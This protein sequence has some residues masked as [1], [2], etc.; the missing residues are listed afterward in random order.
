MN[1]VFVSLALATASANLYVTSVTPTSGTALTLTGS[2]P[3]VPRRVLLTYGSEGSARTLVVTGTDRYGNVISETLAVPS[4]G[5]GTVYTNQDFATVTSALPLGGGWTAAATLGTNGVGSG[6]WIA[7]EWGGVGKIGVLTRVV[8]GAATYSV[9][10]TWDDINAALE[11]NLLP[12]GASV[13]PLSNVPPVAIPFEL[14]TN[15]ATGANGIIDIPVFAFRLTNTSGTGTV[16]M[17]AIET[18]VGMKDI[19]L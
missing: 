13:E 18:T 12:Y 9:E 19:A 10:V 17:Q 1:P 3:A 11:A 2:A 8:T 7:R 6:P 4:G 14:F 5:A 16:T 15:L